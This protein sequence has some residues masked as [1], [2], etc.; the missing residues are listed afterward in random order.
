MIYNFVPTVVAVQTIINNQTTQEI[1]NI[2]QQQEAFNK[3]TPISQQTFNVK[4]CI[5]NNKFY[6]CTFNSQEK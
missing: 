3:K 5:D 1:L 4:T 2:A 6:V